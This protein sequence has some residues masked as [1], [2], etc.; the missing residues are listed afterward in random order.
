[1]SAEIVQLRTPEERAAAIAPAARAYL[2]TVEPLRSIHTLADAIRWGDE[3]RRHAQRLEALLLL[4]TAQRDASD[5]LLDI[6][7]DELMKL[8]GIK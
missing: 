2:A 6:A 1:M 8:R 5:L 3:W 7:E 4:A